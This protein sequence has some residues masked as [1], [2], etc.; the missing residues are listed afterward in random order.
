MEEERLIELAL[1]NNED[2][3]NELYLKYKYIVDIFMHKYHNIATSLNID[4]NELEGEAY[5]SFSDALNS[6][7]K[8]KNVKLSTFISLCVDRRMKKVLKKYS[9]E[10]ARM[11]NNT[12]SLDYDYNEEGTTLK[13]LIQD[14]S[15]SDPL[16]TIENNENYEELIKKISDSLSDFEY[17]VFEYYISGFDYQTIATLT[18]KEPKQIDNTIQ[19]LKHKIR[20]ILK[21][22]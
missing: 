2:A 8:D 17:E 14:E 20:D 10:K 21:S 16:N 4:L 5:L 19:R 12:Y 11:L 15:I 1:Q 22:E 6:Y 3:K 18:E 9:T 7:Q 13:D